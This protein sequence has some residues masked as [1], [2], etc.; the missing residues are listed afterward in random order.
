MSETTARLGFD[1]EAR[2]FIY[3]ACAVV[4]VGLGAALPQVARWAAGWPWIPFQGLLQAI[5][6]VDSSWAMWGRP[7]M[8]LI[9]GIAFA[10]IVVFES[11]VLLVTDAQICVSERGNS[12]TILRADIAGIYRDGS[13]VVVESPQGRRLFH[14]QIEGNKES[15]RDAFVSHGYPWE[16]T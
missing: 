2:A 8:G 13:K 14:G 4:G 6:A 9:L 10:A 16:T 11:P 15:V 7:S 3:S 12:R 1:Q 5:A